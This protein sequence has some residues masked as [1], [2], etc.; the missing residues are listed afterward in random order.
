MA[1]KGDKVHESAAFRLGDQRVLLRLIEAK[2]GTLKPWRVH[3]RQRNGKQTVREGTGFLSLDATEED[4]RE[5]YAWALAEL[6]KRGWEPCPLRG[7]G[8]RGPK[9]LK[10]LP[11]PIPR[12]EPTPEPPPVTSRILERGRQATRRVS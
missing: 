8:P 9:L 12:P 3:T 7:R 1:S 4:G 5:Q 2:P 6:P 11:Q 10:S